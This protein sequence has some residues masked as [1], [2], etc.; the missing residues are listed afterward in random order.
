MV[1]ITLQISLVME[2]QHMTPAQRTALQVRLVS[3]VIISVSHNM[4]QKQHST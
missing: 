3:G 2:T 1:L 4:L